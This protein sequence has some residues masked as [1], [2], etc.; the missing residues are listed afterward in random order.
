MERALHGEERSEKALDFLRE[1]RAL[2]EKHDVFLTHEDEHGGFQ[3]RYGYSALL[4]R[5]RQPWSDE[6][7]EIVEVA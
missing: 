6:A 2:Q 5:Y 4:D 3:V 7:M 1:L